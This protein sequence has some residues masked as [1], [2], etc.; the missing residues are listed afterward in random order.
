MSTIAAVIAQRIGVCHADP[1]LAV[2]MCVQDDVDAMDFVSAAANLRSE[3]FGIA[4]KSHF[5]IKCQCGRAT[6]LEGH[7]LAGPEQPLCFN[8]DARVEKQ[9]YEGVIPC[10][11]G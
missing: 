9:G 8:V 6:D 2:S 5:D 10:R 7:S 11:E 3:V 1:L 4:R